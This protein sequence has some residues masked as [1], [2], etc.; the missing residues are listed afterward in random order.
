[1]PDSVRV[2]AAFNETDIRTLVCHPTASKRAGAAQRICETY[3]RDALTQAD[4]RIAERLL[5]VMAEDAAALVRAALVVTLHNSTELPRDIALKLASDA[6]TIAVPIIR[7]SPVLNDDDLVT[8]LRSRAAA[9]IQAA[10]QRARIGVELSRTIIRYGDSHAVARLAA[11]DGAVIDEDVAREMV[12]LWHDD[13]L[14]AEAMVA[15]RDMPLDILEVLVSHT[16]AETALA[17]ES[18]G[19]ETATAVDLAIRARERATLTLSE[20]A[21][22]SDEIAGLVE[23]LAIEGRLTGSVVM[24]A[25]CQGHIAFA[26]CAMACMAGIS[27]EKSRLM[28]HDHGPF[29]I[30]ALAT[31]AGLAPALHGVLALSLRN[32]RDLARTANL[33]A[34][35]F[36][37]R[38]AERIA[39]SGVELS[40]DD[41]RYVMERLD[42]A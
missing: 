40:E 18:R 15:R 1:M 11:N 16:S 12:R 29:G 4:R 38:L 42:A 19:V 33:S 24:R 8:V 27:V 39:T 30:R 21:S 20:S 2:K 37:G 26:E 14:V 6:D 3:G 28:L 5:H 25:I 10:A 23:Q 41:R 32:Y 34:A 9:K 17:L 13:D 31:K 36:A 22:G 7:F 35:Q